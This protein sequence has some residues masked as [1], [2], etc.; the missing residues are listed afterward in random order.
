MRTALALLLAAVCGLCQGSGAVRLPAHPDA[1]L[2]EGQ[3]GAPLTSL[4]YNAASETVTLQLVAQD[5]RGYFIPGIPAEDFAVYEDGKRQTVLAARVDKPRV[6]LELLLEYGGSDPT[7][8][9][10]L[11]GVDSRDGQQ[12]VSVL[13][14]NDRL[15]I[16]V[17]GDKVTELAGFTSDGVRL[18]SI[19]VNLAPP[20][21]RQTRLYDALVSTLQKM[22]NIPGRKA[23]VLVTS[24]I[25][26]G[27]DASFKDAQRFASAG[28]TPIYVVG[29]GSTLR[30]A[31]AGRDNAL[32]RVNW[33][34]IDSNP[35]AIARA[36]GG[37]LYDQGARL[38]LGSVY[39]D[40]L[41]S[42]KSRYVL[43][44]KSSSRAPRN[45]ARSI[46]VDLI[47]PQTGKP[48]EILAADGMPVKP[49]LF[50][51]QSYIPQG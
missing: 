42:L 8:R 10:N 41:D 16:A 12:L 48:L 43:T 18:D 45:Q 51:Q 7:V 39:R 5:R 49:R 26:S 19:L 40:M 20:V 4:N 29:I 23:I 47:D 2:F 15:G 13:G 35:G 30:A 34:T 1:A 32:A 24:G 31:L 36:S 6:S 3:P 46:R 11:A 50:L 9:Q 33:T 27:S 38:D 17:Y 14:Q 37:R 44:Y 28:N 22:R 25:D 21:A